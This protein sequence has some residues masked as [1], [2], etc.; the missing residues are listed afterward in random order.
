MPAVR[1][2]LAVLVIFSLGSPAS[3]MDVLVAHNLNALN[4]T[5]VKLSCT[6]TSCYKVDYSKFAMNWTYQETVND[7]GD[8]FMTYKQRFTP[9]RTEKF[10]DRVEFVGN[11]DRNDVSVSLSD[12]QISDEG[13]YNCFVRNPPDRVQGHGVINLLVVTEMPTQGDSKIA[14]AVGATVGGLLAVL[15][16]SMVVLKCLR[17]QRK[18]ELVSEE[19]KME[20]DKMEGEGGAEE[21]TK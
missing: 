3:S 8:M 4:G 17:R 16:L 9:V 19:Q 2:C 18:Q 21:G 20:E 1:L 7:T 10:E 14:V 5:T 13:I 11:L 6:F 15:I 12:V